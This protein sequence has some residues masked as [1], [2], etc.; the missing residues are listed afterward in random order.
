MFDRVRLVGHGARHAAHQLRRQLLARREVPALYDETTDY[1]AEGRR[2][3]SAG[4]GEVEEVACGFGRG[5][6]EHLD[7]YRADLGFERHA[8]LRH[9]L[10]R[11]LVERLA[12]R[13]RLRRGSLVLL[14][15]RRFLLRLRR[16]L[17]SRGLPRAH[18]S[19]E[20]RGAQR[21]ADDECCE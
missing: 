8:L 14:R 5:L 4:G 12:L 13:R 20:T 11:R 2:V 15:G 6:G 16:G 10:D 19:R 21:N 18:V 1:P 7:A 3:E 9:L 17:L